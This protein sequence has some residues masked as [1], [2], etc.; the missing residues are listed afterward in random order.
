MKSTGIIR[1]IDELGRIVIPKEIRKNLNI[2]EDDNIE[3]FIDN[4]NIILKKFSS[5]KNIDVIAQRFT[6]SLYSLLKCNVLIT[7]KDIVIASSGKYKKDYIKRSISEKFILLLDRRSGFYEKAIDNIEIVKG[8]ILKAS[9]IME[10]IIANGDILGSVI[11]FK[12]DESIGDFEKKLGQV[13]SSF[14]SKYLED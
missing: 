2:K 4:E 10:P 1:R 8:Y 12:S 3:I 11:I 6:D 9:Y 14:F 5:L 13:V 7:D